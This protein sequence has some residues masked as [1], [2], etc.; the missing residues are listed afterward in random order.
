M[1]DL[2]IAD[3]Q[4]QLSNKK[5]NL[6]GQNV[7][8]QRCILIKVS[9]VHVGND[10]HYADCHINTLKVGIAEEVSYPKNVSQRRVNVSERS[11]YHSNCLDELE[12]SSS[13]RKSI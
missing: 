3:N 9:P 10:A 5:F 8:S 11:M 6:L 12:N 2:K 1:I 4:I 7:A 13:R